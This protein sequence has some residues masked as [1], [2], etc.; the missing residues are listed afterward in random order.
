M[1][2]F[3]DTWLLLILLLASAA[4]VTWWLWPGPGPADPQQS[5]TQRSA[6][7]PVSGAA[8]PRYPVPP[9]DSDDGERVLT[10]LPPLEDSDA[11]FALA[12][13]DLLGHDIGEWLARD[14]LI[15]KLVVTIDNLPR[16]RVAERM[17]PIG[18]IGAAFVA[19]GMADGDRY[20]LGPENY[21]RYDS[22]VATLETIDLDEL[23][24]MYRRFYP[25]FQ[26]A[27]VGLGYPDAY[28]NDRA[29]EVIG[30]LLATPSLEEPIYLVR[31]HVLFEFADPE[32][33]A[34]SAGHKLLIRI[35]PDHASRVK[36]VLED[37]RARIALPEE[38]GTN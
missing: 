4:I 16:Q 32:L 18:Q 34:L 7:A 10:P 21:E 15:E 8:E 29:V 2:R 35:G 33:E 14:A 30:H 27:Y 5:V 24:D 3:G 12:L 20:L 11:Y 1:R 36:A 38:P 9:P 25:L 17:R 26:Q 19:V 22:L 28:F 37:L 31:P 13:A 6:P 23:L